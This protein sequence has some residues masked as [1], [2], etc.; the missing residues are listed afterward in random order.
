M[1]STVRH[2]TFDALDPHALAAFWA[3][4]LGFVENPDDPNLPGDTEVE[5][6]D[7]A[8]RLAPLLFIAVPEEKSGKNRLHLDLAPK[9][10][11]RDAEVDRLLALGATV[12]DDRRNADGTGWVTLLDLEGNELCVVRSGPERGERGPVHAGERA[13]AAARTADERTQLE[14]VLEWYRVGVV[15]KVTGLAPSL[16]GVSPVATATTAAGVV[17]HLALVEDSW[18]TERFAGAGTPDWYADVDWSAQPDWEFDTGRVEPLA[19]SIARYEAACQRS[20]AVASGRDL[21]DLAVNPGSGSD[22]SLRFVYLHLIE[23]TARHLGQLDI[24]RELLD[25]STGE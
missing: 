6:I 19:D 15:A 22:F 1:T 12:H 2:V 10:S 7:P 14:V 13:M 17:K 16:V 4:V 24:L 18:F 3:E 11:T 20:R 8:R 5:I 21:D 23:E 9:G 25:G